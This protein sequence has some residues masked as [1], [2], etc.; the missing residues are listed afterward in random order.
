MLILGSLIGVLVLSGF[1]FLNFSPQF[2]QGAKGLR[3]QQIK[4]S[5][6]YKE[7]KF[8]NTVPTASGIQDWS[9]VPGMMYKFFKV[10]PDQRPNW[11]IPV[12]LL[13]SMEIELTKPTESKLTWFGHSAFLLEMD[14][15]KILL[16]PMLGD[17][18]APAPFLGGK[19]FSKTLPIDIEKLPRIDA[20]IISHDHYDHLDYGSIQKLKNKT[21]KFYVPLGVGAHLE[22]WGVDPSKITE[23]DWWEESM[24]KHIK[25]VATPARHFSGRGLTDGN[26]T[27]WASWV[28]QGRGDKIFF[29]GD[30]GYFEGFK[31]IG[32]KYG[33]F[34]L[35][36]LEC[37]QY[38]EN[39]A[40]IHMIPEE[41]AQACLDV[42]G[43]TLM[44][45]HW[46]AFKLALHSWTDPIERVTKA[47]EELNINITT[48]K[49]GETVVL[50][51]HFPKGQWWKKKVNEDVI[52]NL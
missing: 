30:G 36:M 13:D 41:T 11:D 52:V 50:K 26:Q 32:E 16:D 39:W 4:S 48:P 8:Q 31:E 6:N 10:E 23:L 46:G 24:H 35:A 19:R 22:I 37:G 20:I 25:L 12:E 21:K 1:L 14:G 9:E 49:I 17:V 44:P 38:N 29:G 3:L 27:L 7:G 42:K 15:E 40:D 45:M 51:K 28:I 5:E 43:K 34:D 33:P 47:A 18:P 2:G